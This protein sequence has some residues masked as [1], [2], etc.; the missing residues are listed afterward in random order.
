M[1]WSS[2]LVS[3]GTSL[4]ALYET[5]SRIYYEQVLCSLRVISSGDECL[6]V[7]EQA[8]SVWPF[9]AGSADLAG[10]QTPISSGGF[11]LSE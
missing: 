6:N 2:G 1:I 11:S 3:L 4:A 7:A 8:G 10:V 9:L 5:D